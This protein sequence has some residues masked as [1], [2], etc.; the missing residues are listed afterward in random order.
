[1]YVP[2]YKLFAEAINI[3]RDSVTISSQVFGMLLRAVFSEHFNVS[4]YR[5]TYPDV[6]EAVDRGDISSELTHFVEGGFKEGRM[7]CSFAV[8]EE[9]Y[10][11]TYRD[12]ASAIE[13]G[14]IA[15]GHVHY[16]QS[17]YGEGRLPDAISASISAL[18]IQAI[19]QSRQV[20]FSRPVRHQTTFTADK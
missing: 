15:C 11:H 13:T 20:V 2:P 16:N 7:P 9:W 12:I 14:T 6:A 5:A 18:W 1:M 3:K 19:D 17:G 8:D 10:K 4:W